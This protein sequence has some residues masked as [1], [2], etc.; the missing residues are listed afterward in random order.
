MDWN[1][2]KPFDKDL[3]RSREANW[4]NLRDRFY[5]M[6]P[7]LKGYIS[8]KE[9]KKWNVLMPTVDMLAIVKHT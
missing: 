1:Q 4:K 9:F 3:V 6:N 8:I 2:D 5:E 7:Q